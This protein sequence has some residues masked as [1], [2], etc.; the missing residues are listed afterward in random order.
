VL[1][2]HHDRCGQAKLLFGQDN[3]HQRQ[4]GGL[5]CVTMPGLRHQL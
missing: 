3:G 4:E 2:R 5:L 1:W